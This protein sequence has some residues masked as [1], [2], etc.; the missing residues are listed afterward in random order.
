[1]IKQAVDHQEGWT[2]LGRCDKDTHTPRARA[3]DLLLSQLVPP[4]RPP[5]VQ[6]LHCTNVDLVES[7]SH[8]A[9]TSCSKQGQISIK[10][11]K[12][13]LCTRLLC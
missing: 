3:C 5:V 7:D 10:E 8:T 6:S 13:L 2:L 4:P 11:T 1:M 9:S 12:V